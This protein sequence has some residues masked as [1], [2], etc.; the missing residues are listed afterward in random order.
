MR[1]ARLWG[2]HGLPRGFFLWEV[3]NMQAVKKINNNVALCID[4]AGRQVIAMGKGIGFGPMPRTVEL[5]DIERTFYDIDESCA[6]L[7]RQAPPEL[8]RLCVGFVERA[9]QT[10]PYPISSNAALTLADH[11]QFA[12]QRAKKKIRVAMPLTFELKHQYPLETELADELRRS[13]QKIRIFL[14][15]NETAG[16]AMNLINARI[17]Q[18]GA[19]A[20]LDKQ[21]FEELLDMVTHT[22]EGRLKVDID[23]TTFNFARFATHIYYLAQRLQRGRHIDSRN[24]SMFGKMCDS[25]PALEDCV[26]QIARKLQRCLGEPLMEEEKLY[27]MLH[28]NRITQR[29]DE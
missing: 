18:E 28:I 23:R 20:E 15:D 19:V 10:L 12:H 17:P 29:Q 6:E 14:P 24:L 3:L 13:L 25:F 16:I 5:A 1:F 9:Q 7:F 8:L 27:L 21:D 22:V 4:S 2:G 11:I 26:D